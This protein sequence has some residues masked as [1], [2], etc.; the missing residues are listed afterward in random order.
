[1]DF[2]LLAW[3][4]PSDPLAL[5]I[6]GYPDT[7][8]TWR[9]LGPYLAGRGWRAVA[10]FTRG[11]APTDLAPDDRYRVSDQAGD[12]VAL[13]EAL[14]GDGRAAL[15]GHDWG[16]VATWAVTSSEPDRFASYVAMSVPPPAAVVEPLRSVSTLPLA[17]RQVRMSWYFLLNQLPES[18][19]TLGRVIPKLWVDWSP[20]YDAQEDLE[21]VFESLN[22]PGRRRAALRYYR[23]TLQR[24]IGE[25]AAM[26]PAAPVLYLH[27]EDDGCAQPELGRLHA[28]DLPAGSR[29]EAVPGVGHFLQLEDP[30]LVNRLIAD[31]IASP[32]S[33]LA[34]A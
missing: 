30:E 6:H 13:H 29:F 5:L 11:Y 17:A 9:Y 10:P 12:V 2:G 1:M 33:P 18:E 8:W 32:D 28:K 14:G 26:K 19:R 23:N 15:V 20:G 22:G 25:L 16:A 31:W 34:V 27:G 3:G 21:R 4:E 24:G 7:A